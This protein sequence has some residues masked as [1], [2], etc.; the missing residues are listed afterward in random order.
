MNIP[1]LPLLSLI[2]SKYAMT[3]SLSKKMAF[4][5]NKKYTP[6]PGIEPGLRGPEPQIV[7]TADYKAYRSHTFKAG[8]KFLA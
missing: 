4:C 1:K 7:T 5:L 8:K 6:L 3:L 2:Q